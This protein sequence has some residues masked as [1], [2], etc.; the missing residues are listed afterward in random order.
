[1]C[2]Y[3]PCS[4]FYFRNFY[5]TELDSNCE[6]EFTSEVPK[7]VITNILNDKL[8][9]ISPSDEFTFMSNKITELRSDATDGS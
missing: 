3:K 7:S 5:R 1:M 4:T 8:E 2:A 6:T 9:T